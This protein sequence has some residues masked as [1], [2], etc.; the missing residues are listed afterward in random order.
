[1]KD[2]EQ[3]S[4]PHTP[5]RTAYEVARGRAMEGYKG[6]TKQE[7]GRQLAPY[8]IKELHELGYLLETE[9]D[10]SF[11]VP[12]KGTPTFVS[13]EELAQVLGMEHKDEGDEGE[14]V[15]EDR[16]ST[17]L[18]DRIDQLEDETADS[19]TQISSSDPVR[20]TAAITGQKRPRE[21]QG[22]VKLPQAKLPRR[23]GRPADLKKEKK[24]RRHA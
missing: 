14:E 17:E 15:E 10:P 23:A 2:A 9:L 3:C 18:L 21:E 16:E 5:S 12:P 11:E 22:E 13:E 19:G 6:Y 1:M 24:R 8:R 4:A 20:G 7:L